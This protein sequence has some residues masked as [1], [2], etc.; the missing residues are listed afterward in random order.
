[1]GIYRMEMYNALNYACAYGVLNELGAAVA[2]VGSKAFII[3]SP[4]S[5]E[6]AEKLVEN[7]LQQV[8]IPYEKAVFTAFSSENQARQ[9]AEQAK[10]Y[11]ADLIIGIGGGRTVDVAKFAATIADVKL[12]TV[13]TIS[14]TNASYRRNT[15]QYTD[16]GKYITG[17]KNKRSPMFVFADADILGKQPLRYLYSG[18]IDAMARWYESKPYIDIYPLHTHQR[19]AVDNAKIMYDYFVGNA[20]KITAAFSKGEPS[21]TVIETV[22]NVIGV[23]GVGANFVSDIVLQGFAHPFYN[24]VTNVSRLHDKLHGEIIGYGVLVQMV[25][26]QLPE[27]EIKAELAILQK[28]GFDYSLKDIGI[29]NEEELELLCA[30]LWKADVP[31]VTFF[32]GRVKSVETVKQAILKV[33]SMVLEARG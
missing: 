11:G 5:L 15:M 25:L 33:N 6:V 19:F 13:P 28:F 8:N 9:L 18:I 14:A 32:E 22:T 1:M 31:R 21:N 26:E 16:D 17:F 10:G 3:G 2:S 20:E 23:C 4:K 24:M 12:I 7:Q 27:A 29:V 30:G